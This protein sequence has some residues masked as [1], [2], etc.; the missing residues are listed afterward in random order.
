MSANDPEQSYT[1]LKSMAQ[2]GAF[3]AIVPRY[4]VL[5]DLAIIEAA[6]WLAAIQQPR[7]R[8]RT[9]GPFLSHLLPVSQYSPA[10]Y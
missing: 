6:L 3:L 10:K 1:E 8:G 4:S 7:R 2:S 5:L 9:T